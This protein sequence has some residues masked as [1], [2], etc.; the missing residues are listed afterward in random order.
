MLKIFLISWFLT[1]FTPLKMILDTIPVSKMKPL[2]SILMS[3]IVLP[4]TCLM[5]MSLY[6]GLIMSGD[7]YTAIGSSIVGWLF[8]K[9]EQKI[10]WT[11]L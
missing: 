5:C 9:I 7:I 4:F 3:V 11:R 6:V 2:I 10:E 1:H 8:T